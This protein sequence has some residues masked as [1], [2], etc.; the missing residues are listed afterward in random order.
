MINDVRSYCIVTILCILIC[1]FAKMGDSECV[2]TFYIQVYMNI[3]VYVCVRVFC[4]CM[5]VL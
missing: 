4:V 5:Y 3:Y 1:I 2:A